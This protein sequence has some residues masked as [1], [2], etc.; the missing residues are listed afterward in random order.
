MPEPRPPVVVLDP[1]HGGRAPAGRSSPHGL[2]GPRGTLEKDVTLALARSV[3]R[4]LG[5]GGGVRLTREADLNLPLGERIERARRAGA[6]ERQRALRADVVDQVAG[7]VGPG[8]GVQRVRG[9]RAGAEQVD[10][11]EPPRDEG[12]GDEAAVTPPPEGLGAQ[13]GHSP[14]SARFRLELGERA[15][16]RGGLHVIGVGPEAR[17]LPGDVRRVRPPGPPSAEGV[18]AED[19][20]HAEPGQRL[21]E[22]GAAEVRGAARSREPPDVDKRVGRPLPE[23]LDELLHAAGAV[24]DG[25]DGVHG[26][27]LCAPAA[28]GQ[29]GER[30]ARA[31]WCW[32]NWNRETGRQGET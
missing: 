25:E 14:S 23:Q 29:R 24:A 13:E 30:G 21:G 32:S 12:V 6:A 31:L 17:V 1:G 19:V 18:A 7:A 4:H 27:E 22:R 5:G 15:L 2:R 11:R 20:G 9:L 28:R 16:E 26:E 10:D 3:A 8:G